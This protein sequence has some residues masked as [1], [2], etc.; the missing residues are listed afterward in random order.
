MTIP[1]NASTRI[2]TSLPMDNPYMEFLIEE[3]ESGDEKDREFA[4]MQ[5][6]TLEEY[7]AFQAKD[8]AE[9]YGNS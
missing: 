2:G 3:Q 1:D 6:M 5:G 4:A 7:Q 8:I 9:I